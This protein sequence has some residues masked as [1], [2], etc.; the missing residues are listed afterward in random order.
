MDIIRELG[1]EDGSRF[2]L[3]LEHRPKWLRLVLLLRW[4]VRLSIRE[5]M[6]ILKMRHAS[7]KN[8]IRYLAGSPEP[9]PRSFIASTLRHPLVAVE[10]LSYNEKF[11]VLT[12]YGREFADKVIRLLRRIA[13]NY[14]AV[15]V[16][17]ELG[18]SRIELAEYI[19]SKLDMAN[20]E[21]YVSRLVNWHKLVER[22]SREQ[23][24]LV[25][26]MDPEL[27]GAIPVEVET[28]SGRY[29]LYLVPP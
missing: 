2:V 7:L 25:D 6:R 14:G 3:L 4:R 20:S 21:E 27:I 26:V 28:T 29:I 15:D 18:V 17:E 8:A 16:E 9:G 5:A 11:I 19:A 24:R 23:P 10:M 13:L 12:E 22:L 1:A